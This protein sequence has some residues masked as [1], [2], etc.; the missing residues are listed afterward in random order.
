M[1]GEISTGVTKKW[2]SLCS[3]RFI[4]PDSVL[5]KKRVVTPDGTMRLLQLIFLR[6]KLWM[7]NVGEASTTFLDELRTEN[8]LQ[9]ITV[10]F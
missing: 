5:L 10:P 8:H 3:S 4:A 9:Q 1:H 6:G 7:S 2:H